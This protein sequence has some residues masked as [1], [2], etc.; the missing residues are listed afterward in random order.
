MANTDQRYLVIS[1]LQIPFEAEYALPFCKAVKK[2]YKIPDENVYCVGDETDQYF[3]G[4]YKR[5][6]DALHSAVTELED[7][8]KTLKQWYR[9]F[10]QM[11][12]A[13]SNHGTRYW[14]KALEAEIPSQLLRRYEEVIEAPPGWKWKKRW[15]VKTKFPFAIEHGDDWGSQTPHVQAALHLGM[16]VMMGH[17]HSIFGVEYLKTAG[18]DVWGACIGALIDADQYAFEYSRR[19]KRKPIN[20]IAVVVDDG[21]KVILE[22]YE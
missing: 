1:D 6:P 4:L 16:S 5:S 14:R 11:K 8:R 12:L 20:G 19:M 10:P 2:Y 21:R 13:I 18:L 3:G 7:A 17:H 15:V 22:P 9:A